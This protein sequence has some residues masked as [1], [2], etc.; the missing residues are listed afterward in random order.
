MTLRVCL[1]GGQEGRIFESRRAQV[2]LCVAGALPGA[3]QAMPDSSADTCTST[4][5]GARAGTRHDKARAVS[6]LPPELRGIISDALPATALPSV[7]QTHAALQAKASAEMQ[8]Y[9][10]LVHMRLEGDQ[11]VASVVG[12]AEERVA[13][14]LVALRP[15]A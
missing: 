1:G 11:V 6:S 7:E 10:R 15:K 5:A 14:M 12:G 9:L 13:R 4:R 2:G 8:N 3:T